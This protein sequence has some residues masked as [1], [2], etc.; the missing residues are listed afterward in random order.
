MPSSPFDFIYMPQGPPD[1]RWNRL[2]GAS[3]L[4]FSKS[5]RTALA[6][7]MSRFLYV[8]EAQRVT[9][10]TKPVKRHLTSIEKHTRTLLKLLSP[11]G[12]N[13]PTDTEETNVR[14]AVFGLF[15]SDFDRDALIRH[16]IKL[17]TD[18]LNALKDGAPGPDRDEA[19]DAM[20][21]EWHGVWRQAGGKGR[22]CTR[23]GASSTAKGPFLELL[24]VALQGQTNRVP[25]SL[26]QPN[27]HA[28]AQRIIAVVKD[29]TSTHDAG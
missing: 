11:Y 16:L 10:R 13:G 19:L 5:Q 3:E 29:T 26:I 18:A 23:S 20:I 8:C 28:L 25:E 27:R 22:G 15:S 6:D 14:H 9:A 1:L 2:E 17:R 21:R 24:H 7:S 12:K 4:N